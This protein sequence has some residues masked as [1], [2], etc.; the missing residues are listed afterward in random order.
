[1]TIFLDVLV[2]GLLLI[3][4][5]TYC[6]RGFTRTIL[7]FAKFIV[8]SLAAA[9]LGRPI[10]TWISDKFMSKWISEGVNEKI[11]G[12]FSDGQSLREFFD[13]IPQGFKDV[14]D[15]FNVDIPTL[16]QSY[17]DKVASDSL[18]YDMSGS[19]ATPI[20]NAISA[21]IAY[22]FV[23]VIVL[24]IFNCVLKAVK[25]IKLPLFKG[26]D[27][28]LG[29]FLGIVIGL[30]S[31][32]VLATC[33]YFSFEFVSAMYAEIDLLQYYRDSYVFKF[34]YDLRILQTLLGI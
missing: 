21:I 24:I 14:L 18:I 31:A 17:A 34:I 27:R 2:G 4:T 6:Y 7:E 32:S 16:Y 25:N 28:I 15:L 29:F 8:A 11:S 3:T 5:I 1:M 19:I 30:L 22:L 9:A 10:A 33:L 12:Y 23:F 20:A 13:N 26:I